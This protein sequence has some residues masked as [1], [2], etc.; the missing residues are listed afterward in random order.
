MYFHCNHNQRD[1]CG[2]MLKSSI[3]F[4]VSVVLTNII[5]Y[6]C[7]PKNNVKLSIFVLFLVFEQFI[8][9]LI[10][11]L[12]ENPQQLSWM[13]THILSIKCQR[14]TNSNISNMTIIFSL[15]WIVVNGY[16]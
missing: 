11:K 2:H 5:S 1:G 13:I 4:V 8:E 7:L 14:F 3:K 16:G 9:W 6:L 15:P 12:L 10:N